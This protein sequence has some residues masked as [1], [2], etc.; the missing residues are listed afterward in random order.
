MDSHH[1]KTLEEAQQ[2]LHEQEEAVRE[3]KRFINQ[4]C[5]FAGEAP[6]YADAE[7]RSN[8]IVPLRGDEYYGQKQSTACRLV[9]ER[10]KAANLGPASLDELHA[11]L[12]EGGYQFAAKTA[13]IEKRSL[14]QMLIKNTSIFHRLPNGKFGLDAWYPDTKRQRRLTKDEA[15]GSNGDENGDAGTEDQTHDEVAGAVNKEK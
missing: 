6:M 14:Y 7:Q 2:R 9:L 11:A 3:T 8:A 4:L 15:E 10:R 1:R 13:L 12:L 5:T